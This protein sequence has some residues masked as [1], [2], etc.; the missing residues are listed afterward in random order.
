M[1]LGYLYPTK[2][3]TVKAVAFKSCSALR[4]QY[5]VGVAASQS[6]V[7]SAG[8]TFKKAFV[9]A[10]SYK[11]NRKL[12][13]DNNGIAC[14]VLVPLGSKFRPV[15]LGAPITVNNLSVQVLSVIDDNSAVMCATNYVMPGCSYSYSSTGKT[16]GGVP[17][18][19]SPD[20]WIQVDL[21][22]INKD[23]QARLLEDW[24]QS[25]RIIWDGMNSS[26]LELAWHPFGY[27]DKT[28]WPNAQ[29]QPGDAKRIYAYFF[30]NKSISTKNMQ[31]MIYNSLK[32]P[33]D[34]YWR[35]ADVYLSLNQ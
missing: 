29:L 23:S 3:K 15:N 2:P 30:V 5:P 6:A 9:W 1:G 26:S 21:G 34:P 31:L 4:K 18:I 32:D 13:P 22:V 20:R 7:T 12:D 27:L 33:W 24:R 19:S 14:E 11:L 16:I 10:A 28:A 17:D 35:E 25:L 8:F